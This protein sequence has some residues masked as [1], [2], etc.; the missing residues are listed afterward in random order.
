MQMTSA[1][2]TSEPVSRPPRLRRCRPS[3]SSRARNFCAVKTA[4]TRYAACR[5]QLPVASGR[6]KV[7]GELDLRAP[8]HYTLCCPTSVI[9]PAA[10]AVRPARA[11]EDAALVRRLCGVASGVGASKFPP[12]V[13]S[14]KAGL[15]TC[16]AAAALPRVWPVRPPAP[17]QATLPETPRVRYADPGR[18]PQAGQ[19]RGTVRHVRTR[20]MY[21][22]LS[23]KRFFSTPT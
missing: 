23:R 11:S 10:G 5:K 21:F 7:R 20:S 22:C 18:A 8:M 14:G 19:C 17:L 15:R 1:D 16:C 2:S 12:P 3:K 6:H 13:Q 4:V 9:S